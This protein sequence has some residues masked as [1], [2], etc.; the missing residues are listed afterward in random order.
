MKS[1]T[2]AAIATA[3]SDSGISIVRVSGEDAIKKINDIFVNKKGE[4]ILDS[5]RSHTIHYGFIVSNGETVDEVMVSVMK[6][7]NSFTRE[8]VVEINCHGGV[9]VSKAVLSTV[10]S[11]GFRLAEPG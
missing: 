2:I 7:P 11:T 10:L 9:F 8:D 1:D 3:L 4:H 5:V 6:A